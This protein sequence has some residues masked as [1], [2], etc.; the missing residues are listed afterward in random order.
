MARLDLTEDRKAAL[1]AV[2]RDAV[3]YHDGLSGPALG[4]TWAEGAGGQ[5]PEE[6]RHTLRELWS[7]DLIAVD[8][9]RVHA[10]RGR[11]VSITTSGY[12]RLQRW[13][14]ATL[15]PAA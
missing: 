2:H 15:Q 12:L 7:S 1:S 6:M 8:T 4:Y 11:R 14:Q 10:Q 13:Q 9:H 5:M 3:R